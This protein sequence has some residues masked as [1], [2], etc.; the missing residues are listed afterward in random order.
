MKKQSKAKVLFRML[1]LVKPLSG[2]M[3]IAVIFGT[4]GFL[5]AQ[6]IPVLGGMA[7]LSGLNIGVSM[8]FKTISFL[9]ILFALLR[10][11]FRLSEQRTNH[12]IA[13]TL[14]AIIRD[15]V[16]RA[17][18]RLCPAKLEGRD[19]GDLISLITADVELLEVFYAHT[20]SPICIAITTETIMCLYIG[21]FYPLLGV[22][23]LVAFVLVGVVLPLIISK[24]SGSMGDDLRAGSGALSAHMLES[25]RGIDDTLQYAY[26]EK[27][28]LEITEKTNALSKKQGVLS[29]L[30]GTNLAIANTMIL[31]ADIGM[32]F[33]CGL[34]YQRGSIG[35]DGFLLPLIALMSSFGPVIALSNLG[36]T[37]SSTVASG[38]RILAI[39]DEVPETEDVTG[40]EDV[41]FKGAAVNNLSFSY[42]DEKVLSDISLKIQGKKIIGIIGKS[43][44]GKSTLLKLI[45]RFW[46]TKEG[47]ISISRRSINDINTENL[48]MMES[49]MTQETHLFKD[50]IANNIRIGKLSASDEEVIAAAKKASI[51][52]FIMTLPKGYD[53]EVGELGSTLSGGERQRIGLARAFLHDA[54]F[55]LLD[56]PTSNL[57]SLNE[58]VILKSLKDYKEDKT[59][60]LVSHRESTMR[61]SDE[62]FS[63]DHGR[64]MTLQ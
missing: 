32:L 40:K 53:T 23:A 35:F 20:I 21:S 17:L 55:I 48:R 19:K 43:G 39:I 16:F 2:F 59:V 6:F 15:R 11:V 34:L 22:F 24:R 26:G 58:A 18:R 12:Y 57:D 64:I 38:S 36:T 29:K 9:L 30:T 28:L 8:S 10:A 37:L 50:T 4:L 44:C 25:I 63:I 27:R 1:G 3:L 41:E 13:F 62:T 5:T 7:I 33:L 61:I 45:M 42:N 56:E 60:L 52:D 54:P 49:Y 14:L 46:K 47:E 51:H 31:L